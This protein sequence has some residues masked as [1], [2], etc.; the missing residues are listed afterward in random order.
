M[1]N[2]TKQNGHTAQ[3]KFAISIGIIIKYIAYLFFLVFKNCSINKIV[4]ANKIKVTSCA[5]A[6]IK[7]FNK[8]NI[9]IETNKDITGFLHNL[10]VV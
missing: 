5:L 4:K 8:Y 7:S 2:K 1:V 9:A 10:F 6:V 3:C